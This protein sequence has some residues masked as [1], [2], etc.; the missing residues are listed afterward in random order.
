[1]G[2]QEESEIDIIENIK[3]EIALSEE[4][5]REKRF[6]HNVAVLKQGNLAVFE[7]EE[8]VLSFVDYLS[9]TL[10]IP[11]NELKTLLSGMSQGALSEN[12]CIKERSVMLLTLSADYIFS[13]NNS[14]L[15][16]N[17]LD[18]FLG[19]IEYEKDFITGFTVIMKKLEEIVFRLI[20]TNSW[21][22][23][24][25]V[26]TKLSLIQKNK[27]QKKK[28]FSGLVNATFNRIVSETL[29]K[30]LAENIL[31]GGESLQIYKNIFL[32]SGKNGVSFLL[33]Q[34]SRCS[35]NQERMELIN[36]ISS[37][38][39][40]ASP[41]L[42]E[43]L[44]KEPSSLLVC[45]ILHIM[46]EIGDQQLYGYLRKYL[47]HDDSRIQHEAVRCI[48]KL[49]GQDLSFRIGEA[50]ERVDDPMKCKIIRQ[51][52]ES[53][54]DQ[55][56]TV[57]ILQKLSR[58]RLQTKTPQCL[59]L[60]KTV[61]AVLKKYP[62]PESVEL[63]EEMS[64]ECEEQQPELEQLEF[65]V[66]ESLRILRPRLRHSTRETDNAMET[67][68]FDEDPDLRQ[69][70]YQKIRE[71]NEHINVLYQSGDIEGAGKFIYKEAISAAQQKDFHTAESLRDRLIEI[72]PMALKDAI[73]LGE[74]IDAEKE[75]NM[76]TQYL[77]IWQ[78]LQEKLA[79]VEVNELFNSLR[80]EYFP[81]DSI[82][83]RSGEIDDSLYFLNSGY[84]GLSSVS[85][86]NET[87]LK[88]MQPGDLIGGEH[89]FSVSV[90]TVTLKALTE[91]EV[92][93][94]SREIFEKITEIY[95]HI[96]TVLQ[97]HYYQ[98]EN[99]VTLL[100]MAGDDRRESPRYPVTLFI[101]NMLLDPYGDREQ[102]P[103]TGE[104]MDISEGG[105]AFVVI[106]SKKDN[107]KLLLGRQVITIIPLAGQKEIQCLGVIV[108]VRLFKN[109]VNNFSVHVRLFKKIEQSALKQLIGMWE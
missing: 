87:F 71:T 55:S 10:E 56:D 43:Y 107:A 32:L 1:M 28:V 16:I 79:K 31:E 59:E 15:I 57:R 95:P 102:R 35:D 109:D 38:G 4:K 36:L 21:S 19:W 29:L 103:F 37:F 39:Y 50:L 58:K 34:L 81:K 100:E 105:L 14:D 98:Q 80:K 91:V 66:K 99:I 67:I 26:L 52:A 46:A 69:S 62:L 74:F 64:K 5:R 84:I 101:R 61:A 48:F 97:E 41:I 88:R 7:N 2:K 53:D 45:N 65:Q 24:E 25:R 63:L 33:E 22:D 6:Q 85:G 49:E 47:D 83:V 90:W 42:V 3:K 68:F 70:T 106:L 54:A 12:K 77:Q 60:L 40:T 73:E 20:E 86:N 94:L 30:T 89:F 11:E 78:G 108:G 27:I 92:Q 82:L 104:L 44:Q 76:E 75:R 8:F 51:L 93:V 17:I 72:N 13:Q 9:N 96:E 18:I 23:V